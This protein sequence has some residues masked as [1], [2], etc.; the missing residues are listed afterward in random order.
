[1]RSP[2]TD[3][4]HG[5]AFVLVCGPSNSGKTTLIERLIPL[6]RAAG[7]RVGTIKHAHHGFELDQ[8]GKDSWRH[9]RA[10]AEAVALIAPE[11]AAWLIRTPDGLSLEQA[12]APMRGRVDVVLVEGLKG[13]DGPRIVLEPSAGYRVAREPRQCRVGIAVVE[14]SN[15]ELERLAAFCLAAHQGRP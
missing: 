8:P 2:L 13:R 12:V 4:D 9:A 7:L 1:M 5:P 11:R 10:G 14:L 15:D 3:P 6:V